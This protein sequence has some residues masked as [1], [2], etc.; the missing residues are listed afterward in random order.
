MA[1]EMPILGGTP[2]ML[3]K[4]PACFSVLCMPALTL[5]HTYIKPD[6]AG[7]SWSSD[8]VCFPG[9]A[10]YTMSLQQP[11]IVNDFQSGLGKTL[12]PRDHSIT[13]HV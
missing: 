8:L 11:R 2:L 10:R 9:S 13:L 3:E 7:L 5:G 6:S 4:L 12:Q 1:L